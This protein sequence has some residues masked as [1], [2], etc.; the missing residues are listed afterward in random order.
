MIN[1][2]LIAAIAPVD[3][4]QYNNNSSFDW[5]IIIYNTMFQVSW[6]DFKALFFSPMTRK[7]NY[8]ILIL[9][10]SHKNEKKNSLKMFITV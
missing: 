1:I 2:P 8:R 7:F 6:F 9:G 4:W 3:E 10:N 5:V